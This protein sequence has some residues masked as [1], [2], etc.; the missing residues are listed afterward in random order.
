MSTD[1]PAPNPN[2]PPPPQQP[3]FP[4]QGAPMPQGGMPPGPPLPPPVPAQKKKPSVVVRILTSIAGLVV[5][6][7][8][9]YGFN[10]F[11]SDAAQTKAGDCASVTGT[12]SKPDYKTVACGAAEA[13]YTVGKVLGGPGESCGSDNYDQYT[14][15]RRRGPDSKLCLVPIM[16]EGNCYQ[17]DG[18]AMGY[19]KVDCSSSGAYKL[20]KKVEGTEDEA[21]CTDGAPLTY[22]EPKLTLCFAPTE[23]A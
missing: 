11:T 22:P 6:A 8:V 21:A 23:N 2:Y 3:P 1:A 14:E 16:A 12:Q 17:L 4:P 18:N 19:P 5:A 20:V 9:I 7:L 10:Y 13:N 15:T